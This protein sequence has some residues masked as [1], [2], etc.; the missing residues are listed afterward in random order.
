MGVTNTGPADLVFT[1]ATILSDP[2]DACKRR[3]PS[4][5][6]VACRAELRRAGCGDDNLQ[7]TALG[8]LAHVQ[9]QSPIEPRLPRE[10][11]NA[12]WNACGGGQQVTA[13]YPARPRRAAG[14]E[15]K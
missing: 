9:D 7:A 5:S 6:P 11:T 15:L 1:T 4:C 12:F 14:G 2:R 13:A 8:L 10:I 3:T